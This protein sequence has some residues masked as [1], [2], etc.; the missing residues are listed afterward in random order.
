MLMVPSNTSLMARINIQIVRIKRRRVLPTSTGPQNHLSIKTPRP[1]VAVL[2][3]DSSLP[4]AL[5]AHQHLHLGS[6]RRPVSVSHRQW[7]LVRRLVVAVMQVALHLEATRR[8]VH[9]PLASP[10]LSELVVEQHLVS[11]Q[12]LEADQQHLESLVR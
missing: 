11:R 3:L 12:T 5:V 4:Q 7:V 9:Q 6:L 10:Q 8:A 2:H 1:R